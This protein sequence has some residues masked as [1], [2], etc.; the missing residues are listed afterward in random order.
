LTVRFNMRERISVA[1]P[2]RLDLT[3]DALR[4]LAANVVDIVAPDGTYYRAL[5][6]GD[7]SSLMSVTQ[8][9]A[10]S[11]EI[12][13]T[14]KRAERFIPTLEKMLGTAADLGDWQ[15]RAGRVPWLAPIA[16]GLEGVKPPRYSTLWEAC[17]HAVTFQQISIHAAAAIMRRMVEALG[18]E[19]DGP[20]T[21]CVIFPTPQ[22]F[23]DA[24]ERALVAAGLSLNKR[25]HLRAIA[26]AIV[27]GELR[28]G[29]IETL[30]TPDASERLVRTRGIGPWSAAVVLL[31]GFGRLDT[32][33]MRDSGV[34]R[35]VRLL[36]GDVPVDLDAVLKTLGPLRGMLYYHLL[37]GRLRNLGAP[38]PD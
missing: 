15:Q 6:D 32:F 17:A 14:G 10:R 7:G 18:E 36:A 5:S 21:R 3:V 34:A 29:E 24:D 22:R 19:V 12:R 2:Y 38:I 26:T 1:Q 35:S 25:A 20:A 16:R 8:P 11:L 13:G 37:L 33:P 30:P 9:D 31:R 28:E 23:L 4:R 27:D